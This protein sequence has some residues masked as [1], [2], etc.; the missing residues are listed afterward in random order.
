MTIEV[1]NI[2]WGVNRKDLPKSVM[3]EVDEDYTEDPIVLEDVICNK[4]CD[5]YIYCPKT[6]NYCY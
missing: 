2:D 4:L 5:A 1:T 3:V 6:F